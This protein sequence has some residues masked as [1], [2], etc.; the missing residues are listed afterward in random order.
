M[1]VVGVSYSILSNKIP[2]LKKFFMNNPTV[3]KKWSS[4]STEQE[5]HDEDVVKQ[6][7]ELDLGASEQGRK[8][9]VCGKYGHNKST[10]PCTTCG[11]PKVKGICELCEE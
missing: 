5:L 11:I 10:C 7:S 4:F 2:R 8:C 9:S 6:W 1:R 3:L